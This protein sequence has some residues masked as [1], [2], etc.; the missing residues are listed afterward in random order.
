MLTLIDETQLSY[1]QHDPVRPHID[2]NFR[3]TENR[4]AFALWYNDEAPAAII[5]SAF[6]EDVPAT[7]EE[8]DIPG[9]V[10]VFYTVWSYERGA[11]A[12]VVFDAVEWIKQNMPDVDRFVTLSP[13]TEMAERF[14]LKN[15]A[16]K[17]RVN[18][19]TVNFEYE[20]V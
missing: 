6:C 7:E 5:C 13:P 20:D 4:K 19:E 11:G 3:I 15:G 17:L 18:E 1:F 2:A 10:A 8:L 9:N 16:I 12:E 14:H